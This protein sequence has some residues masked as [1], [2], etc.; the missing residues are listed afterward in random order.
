MIAIRTCNADVGLTHLTPNQRFLWQMYK[1]WKRGIPAREF[2][3]ERFTDKE[4]IL[5][6]DNMVEEKK[7]VETK[8]RSLMNK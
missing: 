6:I 5:M 1:Y 3:K 8:M 7:R 2:R 4:S